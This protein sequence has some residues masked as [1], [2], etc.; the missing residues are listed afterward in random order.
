M[1][2]RS[3]RLR[4]R[5]LRMSTRKVFKESREIAHSKLLR[6]PPQEAASESRGACSVSIVDDD[7]LLH[8]GAVNHL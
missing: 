1:T 7:M 3:R 2:V 5:E 4:K 6:S 8:I